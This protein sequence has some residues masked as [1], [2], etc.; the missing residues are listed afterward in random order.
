[1]VGIVLV[2]RE[3]LLE[4]AV[5]LSTWENSCLTMEYVVRH[6]LQC[7]IGSQIYVDSLPNCNAAMS[8]PSS[9]CR[10]K[11]F[12][13]V[14]YLDA[15]DS[16]SLL[17][18][19]TQAPID[20]KKPFVLLAMDKKLQDACQAAS[21]KFGTLHTD[22]PDHAMMLQDPDFRIPDAK[23]PNGYWVDKLRVDETVGVLEQWK[24][25]GEFD[26]V[27]MEERVAHTIGQHSTVA[28][29][30]PSGKL[31]AYE[32]IA[33]H[34]TMGML[35]VD[36]GHRRK[37][38]ATFVINLLSTRMKD[39]GLKRFIHVQLDNAVSIK[40][41]EKCGFALRSVTVV[42]LFFKPFEATNF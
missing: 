30:D 17:A 27:A 39:A 23:I 22:I 13:T 20:W 19:L 36:P 5:E 18:L 41:H 25:T 31:V 37:G 10:N 4:L 34:G 9:A 3:Q 12:K 21:C 33:P 38:L 7:N 1:M 15:K 29:R 6:E 40:L 16:S 35:H 24:F 14:M 28:V 2:K 26:R 42:W 8:I 11:F 32:M